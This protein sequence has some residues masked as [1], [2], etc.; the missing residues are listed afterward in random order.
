MRSLLI[1][2]TLASEYNITL[3]LA[4]VLWDL[5]LT[6][7][8]AVVLLISTIIYWCEAVASQSCL[9]VPSVCIDRNLPKQKKATASLLFLISWLCQCWECCAC[10]QK[11][12]IK[13][14]F[15]RVFL[16]ESYG[17]SLRWNENSLCQVKKP[18]MKQKQAH[19]RKHPSQKLLSFFVSIWM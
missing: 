14:A 19:N 16:T 9:F 1:K 18:Q 15:N 17:Y 11:N 10:E 6:V 13:L 7:F 12:W 2:M 4:I 5:F 8:L 3:N